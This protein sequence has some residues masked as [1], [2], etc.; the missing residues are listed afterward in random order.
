MEVE[1]YLQRINWSGPDEVN[2]ET[3]LQLQEHHML[4]IPFENLDVIRK[5]RIPL[6]VE[7]Y[8][9]KVVL[10][11][12][13]GFC[14]ELNGLFNWLL[15][16]LGFNSRLASATVRRPDGGWTLSGSHACVIVEMEKPYLVD[17]GFGDS[18]RVPLPLTGEER[19]DVSGTYRLA[20]LEDGCFDLQKWQNE[21]GWET[22]YR[23][24]TDLRSLNDF[25]EVCQYN[26]TSPQSPFTRRPLVTLATPDGR[27]TLSGNTL[28]TTS[29][30]K[31]H[32]TVIDDKDMPTVLQQDFGIDLDR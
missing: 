7:A 14:Y 12:R 1:R 23:L 18:V 5:V 20:K 6:D 10:N 25:D 31:K 11:H 3:L 16:S 2:L 27:L 24:D 4:H 28:T 19:N 8:F 17:V 21:N 29:L 32:K 13:G 15:Q 22:L 30:D 26:Q 9:R